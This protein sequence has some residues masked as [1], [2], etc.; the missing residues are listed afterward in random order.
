HRWHRDEGHAEAQTVTRPYPD[1]PVRLR[2]AVRRVR[3]DGSVEEPNTETGA[4]HEESGGREPPGRAARAAGAGARVARG[5]GRAS[6]RT[7]VR[8]RRLTHAH[9]AG[10]SGL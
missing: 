6:N 4:P 9:G 2:P 1:C 8:A 5:V 10:E 7:F 3:Q